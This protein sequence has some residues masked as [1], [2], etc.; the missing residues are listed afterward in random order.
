MTKNSPA[1]WSASKKLNTEKETSA[2]AQMLLAGL[3]A[4]D[5]VLFEGPVGAGKSHLA[6]EIIRGRLSKAGKVEDIPSPTFT[7]VQ[8]Y[9]DGILEIWHCDLY[10]LTSVDEVHELGLTD[11]FG[12]ALCLVEWPDRLGKEAPNDA[13]T[14]YLGISKNPGTRDVTMTANSTK[15]DWLKRLPGDW[16][17]AQ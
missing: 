11:A 1:R 6:R 12:S 16:Q 10:R 8:T 9:D 4:G 14:I 13:L 2:L 15:W 5:V 17:M 7:L 3:N